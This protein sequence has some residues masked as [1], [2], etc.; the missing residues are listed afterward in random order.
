M[1]EPNS[2]NVFLLQHIL[3]WNAQHFLKLYF[4][5]NL[6]FKLKLQHEFTFEVI[7]LSRESL[8]KE[9]AQ[10]SWPTVTNKFRQVAFN[11]N[12]KSLF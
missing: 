6:H 2:C 5:I 11:T 1:F 8:L 3:F 10:Y 12:Y 7:L 9:K 4:N